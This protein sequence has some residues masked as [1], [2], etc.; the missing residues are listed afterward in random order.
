[1]EHWPFRHIMIGL[2]VIAIWIGISHRR[3]AAGDEKITHEA[4]GP[5][6][7]FSLRLAGLA[8][9]LGAMAYMIHPPWMAW[10]FMPVPDWARW[11][12]A[13]M[14]AVGLPYLYWMFSHLGTNVTDT[15]V[16]RRDAYLVSTGPYRWIRHPLYTMVLGNSVG[17]PLLTASWFLGAGSLV[18]FVIMAFRTRKEERHLI[19]RFGD[20]YR[21]YMR[22]TGRFLP[23]LSSLR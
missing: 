18:C 12:G 7:F 14:G 15:V 13:A 19:E 2:M 11:V 23:R 8:M 4:E 17:L 10:S 3:R 21:D 1:M 6:M 20:D 5:W 16:T 22:R 9:W